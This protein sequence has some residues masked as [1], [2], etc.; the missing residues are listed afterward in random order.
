MGMTKEELEELEYGLLD[1]GHCPLQDANALIKEIR[2]LQWQVANWER[3]EISRATE[4]D[5]HCS[6]A[7]ADAYEKA[8]AE[9]E[10]ALDDFGRMARRIRALPRHSSI[11]TGTSLD[12][13]YNEA[14]E[15]AALLCDKV[16]RVN[17]G[18]D[19]REFTAEALAEDIRNLKR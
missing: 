4:C 12:E 5:Q 14:M 19:P 1:Y 15:T 18:D 11:P 13:M 2:S 6:I 17:R 7:E 3:K 8:A 16:A 10:L 9:C